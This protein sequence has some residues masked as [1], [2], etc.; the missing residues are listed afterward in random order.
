MKI[1]IIADE[2]DPYLWSRTGEDHP[3]TDLILSCGDL[4]SAYLQYL[5]TVFN[6][7]LLYIHGN[8][9]TQYK[10]RPPDG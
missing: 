7:P 10:D 6:C 4:E 5:V 2:Q 1:L 9:D 8:H 3:E